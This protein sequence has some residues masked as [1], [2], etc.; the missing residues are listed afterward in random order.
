[1]SVKREGLERIAKGVAKVADDWGWKGGKEGEVTGTMYVQN[2]MDPSNLMA[3]LEKDFD[4]YDKGSADL[5]MRWFSDLESADVPREWTGKIAKKLWEAGALRVR[6]IADNF[7][8]DG[9]SGFL[10]SFKHISDAMRPMTNEQRETFLNLLPRWTGTLETAAST[11]KK[12][13]RR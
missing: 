7:I 10:N 1:M 5:L 4:L 12:L 6:G 8:D 13:Y 9:N 3:R 2:P 11:A